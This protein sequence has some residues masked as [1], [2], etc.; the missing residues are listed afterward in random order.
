MARARFSLLL[1]VIGASACVD[2]GGVE[3]GTATQEIVDGSI[4]TG[5]PAVVA[6]LRNGAQFCTG[7]LIS[8]KHVLTAA[9]CAFPNINIPFSSVS[10]FFGTRIGGDGIEID[11]VDGL[12]HPEWT[13]RAVP[14]D[15]AVLTLAEEASV[16]P[17]AVPGYILE[18]ADIS[19]E[20]G[21]TI[22][23]GITGK[24]Q[25]GNGIKRD[26]EMVMDDYDS[27]TIYLRDAPSAT[28]NGD[29][30]GPLFLELDGREV[31]AGIHSRSNCVDDALSERVDRHLFNFV[32]P[33]V[34]GE[35]YEL[36]NS[37]D[38]CATD[39]VCNSECALDLDCDSV[40]FPDGGGCSSSGEEHGLAAFL[41]VL[42]AFVLSRRRKKDLAP[43]SRDEA[44]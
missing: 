11:V 25:S 6:L 27:N 34:H 12:A 30:G 26:G 29:S 1:L 19:S 8:P 18:A 28:C 44:R 23:F 4:S 13:E 10:V 41:L 38:S 3:F 37:E 43:V 24:S 39:D 22:G 20:R 5:D 40:E 42:A 7:T 17:V 14:N 16:T 2:D 33:Y 35:G 36:T 9:H 15:V 31:L 32:A 21:R